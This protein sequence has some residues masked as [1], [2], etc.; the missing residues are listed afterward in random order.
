MK[1][2]MQ[3]IQFSCGMVLPI[4][5]S[6]ML[7][8]VLGSYIYFEVKEAIREVLHVEIYPSTI[9]YDCNLLEI[10]LK[11]LK[12][13]ASM[14]GSSNTV[15][16]LGLLLGASIGWVFLYWRTKIAKV[17]AEAAKQSA[18]IAEQNTRNHAAEQLVSENS[19]VRLNSVLI[20]EKIAETQEEARDQI[21]QILATTVRTFAQVDDTQER[22]DGVQKDHEFSGSRKIF[23]GQQ[24]NWRE[25]IEAMVNAL[26]RIT[27]LYPDE[28]LIVCNLQGTDLR[29]LSLFGVNLPN[30]N[31]SGVNLAGVSLTGANLARTYLF[32]A[33]LSGARLDR[34]NLSG[35]HLDSSNLS[36]A[37][38]DGVNLSDARL[39]SVDFSDARLNWA[40]LSNARLYWT[41]LGGARLGRVNLS[42]AR[43]DRAN[44]SGARLGRANLSGASLITSN[45]SNA[46]FQGVEGL[47]QEQLNEAFYW[48]GFPPL[49]LP[50]KLEL[51]REKE[52][53]VKDLRFTKVVSAKI[54]GAAI[55]P[56]NWDSILRYMLIL[57][58]KK[59]QTK[60]QLI[61]IFDGLNVAMEIRTDNGYK[62]IDSIGI[63]YRITN[64]NAVRNVVMRVAKELGFVVDIK[65]RWRDH[66]KAARLGDSGR[67][68]V[69]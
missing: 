32:S 44:L 64:A 33:D 39:N 37:R 69:N 52:M 30:F 35:T 4:F 18:A 5:I 41:N 53:P 60:N 48:K 67:I 10:I 9:E 1:Q 40:D 58:A 46:D 59:V 6:I 63:S 27:A 7:F 11:I 68:Q 28:K 49:N 66:K 54:N 45:I 14:M 31:L 2:I 13:T 57:A 23:E 36:G 17:D 43:L 29:G 20:L 8:A 47:T 26:S 56:P 65:F 21:R 25:D 24:K 19:T 51:P 50:D 22:T 61:D 12:E 38:L 34:A 16:N 15:R 55:E 62:P 3:A 42:G